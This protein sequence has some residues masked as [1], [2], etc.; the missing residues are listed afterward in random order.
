[1]LCFPWVAVRDAS[2]QTLS[3]TSPP[4][5]STTPARR[6]HRSASSWRLATATQRPASLPA[7]VHPSASTPSASNSAS[8]ASDLVDF[9]AHR[10]KSSTLHGPFKRLKLR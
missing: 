7:G 9:N 8:A 5:C 2:P 6:I 4:A 1:M 10:R 3:Y